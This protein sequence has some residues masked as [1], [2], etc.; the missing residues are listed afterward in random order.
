MARKKSEY[1]VADI[2]YDDPERPYTIPEGCIVVNYCT[3]CG[4]ETYTIHAHGNEFRYKKHG[5]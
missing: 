5:L 1:V 3:V 4:R 2:D